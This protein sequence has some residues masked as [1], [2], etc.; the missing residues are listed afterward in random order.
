MS[1]LD[2]NGSVIKICSFRDFFLQEVGL[3]KFSS[4][5]RIIIAALTVFERLGEIM[6]S[7]YVF[8]FAFCILF[9][10]FYISIIFIIFLDGVGHM[11]G[12]IAKAAMK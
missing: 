5:C 4:C 8:F 3:D 2:S 1:V 7:W 6:I 9:S 10:F 12:K 11:Y